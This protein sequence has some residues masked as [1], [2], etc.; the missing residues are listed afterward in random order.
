V[1]VPPASADSADA[2]RQ[3]IVEALDGNRTLTPIGQTSVGFLWQYEGL[4]D[5]EAPGGPGPTGTQLGLW[6]AIG[7]AI[8]FG[9]TL[10]LAIPAQRRRRVRSAK[11]MG[12]GSEIEDTTD[13]SAGD[14]T[15]ER[16]R[17]DDDA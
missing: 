5:G 9:L 11:A 6:I 12:Q 3:R 7:Q 8:V 16:P 4:A 10:L 15:A 14:P 1:L 17:G 2:T 13:D